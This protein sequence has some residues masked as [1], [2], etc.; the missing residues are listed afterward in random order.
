VQRGPDVLLE[1]GDQLVVERLHELA[2]DQAR[3]LVGRREDDV[4]LQAAG[5]EL[6]ERLVERVE[7][8]DPD[9]HALLL[10][11]GLQHLGVEVVGVVV[12]LQLA[13]ALGL[14]RARDRVAELG[15]DHRVV[16]ARQRDARA[17]DRA[18]G[19]RVAENALA[20]VAGALRR[21]RR[22]GVLAAGQRRAG[23]GGERE[24]AT[25]AQQRPSRHAPWR[26][27]RL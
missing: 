8:G 16:A 5:A 12:D 13:A 24:R 17:V 1:V 10:A 4:E 2:A 20:A 9:A 7:G 11:E 23:A 6:R 19:G 21:H 3:E 15:H 14:D 18:A 26:F 27:L 22:G 25:A